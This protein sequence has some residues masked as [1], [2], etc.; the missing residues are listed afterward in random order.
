MTRKGNI[1]ISWDETIMWY[2]T[3]IHELEE[4]YIV[5]SLFALNCLIRYLL[6]IISKRGIV[7]FYVN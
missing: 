5:Q 2:V 3:Y 4:K 7:I 6:Q 1:S